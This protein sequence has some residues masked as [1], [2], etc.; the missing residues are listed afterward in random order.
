MMVVGRSSGPRHMVTQSTLASLNNGCAL[1][2]FFHA[3]TPRKFFARSVKLSNVLSNLNLI[4]KVIVNQLLLPHLEEMFGLGSM[5]GSK[6]SVK[7][8]FELW[9]VKLD[10]FGEN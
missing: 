3:R 2:C 5:L 1:R 9:I 4:L 8:Q 6:V 10:L 7:I